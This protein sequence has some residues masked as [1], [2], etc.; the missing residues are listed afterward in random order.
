MILSE[1]VFDGGIQ[2]FALK[3]T[4]DWDSVGVL[5]CSNNL[6]VSENTYYYYT[7]RLG[8]VG[9]TLN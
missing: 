6:I 7:S 9:E 2:V 4:T 1:K 8:C 5:T 3:I